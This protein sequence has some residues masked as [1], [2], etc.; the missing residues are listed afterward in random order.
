MSMTADESAVVVDYKSSEGAK[1][2]HLRSTLIASSVNTLRERGLLERYLR[3]LPRTYH[4][5]LLAPQAPSWIPIEIAE[6]HYKSCQEMALSEEELGALWQTVLSS[7]VNT[8][9]AQFLRSSR[10]V[11]GT[12]WHSLAQAER[13]F[14]RLHRGGSLR[15]TRRGP[16]EAL[17]ESRGCTLYRI[18]YFASGYTTLLR[19]AALFFAKTAYA[20]QLSAPPLEHRVVLAWV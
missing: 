3:C 9:M 2:T 8:M 7:V 17:I 6:L 19:S 11:G 4:E 20:R 14:T 1:V 5:E 16:K 12:P 18:P 10:A 15:V 13:L